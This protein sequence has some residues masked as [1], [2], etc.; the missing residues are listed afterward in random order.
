[1]IGFALP[2]LPFSLATEIGSTSVAVLSEQCPLLV[3]FPVSMLALYAL[4]Y[5]MQ[6]HLSVWNQARRRSR[7]SHAI[8]LP[9]SC[10]GRA[11]A[12]RRGVGGPLHH[13]ESRCRSLTA[14]SC[15]RRLTLATTL[16]TNRAFSRRSER[17]LRASAG[18]W[19]H[20][21]AAIVLGTRPWQ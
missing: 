20:P 3:V 14:Q 5:W 13:Y 18:H 9:N 1:V 6:R 11:A 19:P 16:E 4:S 10:S 15:C 7:R 2:A 12:D 17:I 21:C 8:A